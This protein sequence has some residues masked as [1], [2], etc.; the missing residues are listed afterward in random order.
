MRLTRRECLAALTTMGVASGCKSS[1]AA[2][3]PIS[4]TS[5]AGKIDKTTGGGPPNAGETPIDWFI[6]ESY[7]AVGDGITDD[8]D[9]FVWMCREISK[10]GGG[11]IILRPTTYRVGKHSPG[12]TEIYAYPPGTIMAL[13]GC[14]NDLTIEGNGARLKCA[15][16][17][18]YGTFDPLTG[19]PTHH[20]MPYVEWGEIACPYISMIQIKN[21]SGK[22]RIE[23]LELD[24]NLPNLYIGGTFGDTG[25]QI[26]TAGLRL[27]NNSGGE[28]VSGVR[29]HHHAQDG[30]YIDNA[31]DRLGTTRFENVVSEYNGRQGC[32]IVGG[33]NYSFA[34]CAF[35][36]SGRGGLM[37]APGAGVDIEAERPIR[38]LSFSGCEFSNNSGV[39]LVADS[40]DSDGASFENC[41]FIGTTTWSAWPRMPHFRFNNSQFVGAICGTYFDTD[42]ERAAQFV[43]CRFL[44]DPKL[45]PSGEVFGPSQPIANLGAG[46]QNVLFDGCDFRLSN[47][48]VLPWTVHAIF[49]NCT[50]Y[51]VSN[52]LA[53]PRGTWTGT[54]TITGNADL[55]SSK[56]VGSVTI[57]GFVIPPTDFVGS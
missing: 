30:I 57:N 43:N 37:S 42:P 2:Q 16:G 22:V 9:A 38:N 27:L 51:Q 13:E 5:A 24:G 56:I 53:C 41:R 49:N 3:L 23:N 54:N 18:R 31:P 40:G 11:T 44:D 46:D 21:C 14:T 33:S 25:W 29:S 15:D 52:E 17:L 35:N 32:S 28:Q 34:N 19:A 1:P 10:M 12:R 26:G 50:M 45:S 6:P 47:T 55:H 48:S 4:S 39:G 20:S 8:T 36:H 7:G